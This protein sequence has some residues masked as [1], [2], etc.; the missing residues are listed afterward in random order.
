MA[1]NAL[2]PLTQGLRTGASRKGDQPQGTE[3]SLILDVGMGRPAGAAAVINPVAAAHACGYI[4]FAAADANG[5]VTYF[6]LYIGSDGKVRVSTAAVAIGDADPLE[7]AGTVVG[8]Q[9]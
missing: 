2:T 5:A 4:R 6:D 8:G 9:S 7:N 3:G 1:L